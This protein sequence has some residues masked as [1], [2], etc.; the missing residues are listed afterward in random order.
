MLRHSTKSY[1]TTLWEI[2]CQLPAELLPGLVNLDLND[3]VSLDTAACTKNGSEEILTAMHPYPPVN[4]LVNETMKSNVLLWLLPRGFKV[5]TAFMTWDVHLEPETLQSVLAHAENLMR[6]DSLLGAK[7]HNL[8]VHL[9]TTVS[10]FDF[11]NLERV[12]V[13]GTCNDQWLANLVSSHPKLK[14]LWLKKVP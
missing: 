13:L 8:T 1:M 4:V 14:Q 5:S 9:P 7:V 3:L 12:R 11:P 10:P 6:L 2:V